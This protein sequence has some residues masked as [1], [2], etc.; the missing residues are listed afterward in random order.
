MED[1]QDYPAGTAAGLWICVFSRLLMILDIIR[2][3]SERIY[4]IMGI[5][6][7]T[8]AET[9]DEHEYPQPELI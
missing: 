2:R 7:D 3:K 5:W 8:H 4:S 9:D 6:V 1:G